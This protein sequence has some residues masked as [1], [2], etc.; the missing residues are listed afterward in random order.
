MDGINLNIESGDDRYY[1]E[2]LEQFNRLMAND[3]NHQYLITATPA[4]G[5]PIKDFKTVFKTRPE[6]FD[7]LY[8][9]HDY[10]QNCHPTS[11]EFPSN[12]EKWVE[13]IRAMNTKSFKN[14]KFYLSIVMSLELKFYQTS[15][16]KLTDLYKSVSLQ[17][18]IYL[19]IGKKTPS[20]KDFITK[21][22]CQTKICIFNRRVFIGGRR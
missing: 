4:C 18:I 14:T 16:E 13:Y 7:A 22:T 5:F 3:R 19:I 15:I 6:Y 8:I 11:E 9:R 1:T 2:M 21:N 12:L 20:V 10:T 17:N